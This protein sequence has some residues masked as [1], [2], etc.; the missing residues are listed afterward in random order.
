MR[1]FKLMLAV[2]VVL[3][4][5]FI[6]QA[7]DDEQSWQAWLHDGAG[8]LVLVNSNG[9]R[10]ERLTLPL[11][12]NVGDDVAVYVSS[13]NRFIAYTFQDYTLID[14]YML[15]IYRLE[16][17]SLMYEASSAVG[18]SHVV[19]N[20]DDSQLAYGVG[21]DDA[22]LVTVNLRAGTI[23]NRISA[24]DDRFPDEFSS[25][26]VELF[27]PE[28]YAQER[29][30]FSRLGDGDMTYEWDIDLNV[31]IALAHYPRL[32]KVDRFAPSDEQITIQNDTL[33]TY[34]PLTRTRAPFF[35]LQTLIH[36]AKFVG[37]GHLILICAEVDNMQE[38]WQLLRRDGTLMRSLP[39]VQR[40]DVYNV[41]EG[42]V[43]RYWN[44]ARQ[45]TELVHYD[46]S[47]AMSD[48]TVWF[49][50]GDW[51]IVWVDD[52]A[53]SYGPYIPWAQIGEPF[54]DP[55]MPTLDVA[56]QP[57]GFP[58][59]APIIYVGLT[60]V[61]NTVDGEVLYLRDEPSTGGGIV[62]NLLDGM[63]LEIIGESVEQDGFVWWQVVN[64][65]GL[66]GWAAQAVDTVTT[67]LPQ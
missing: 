62:M 23:I 43:Y 51:Q 38:A 44:D 63:E 52:G 11:P 21:G 22:E 19:F 58:T 36:E 64:E 17:N 57:T 55:P 39:P 48:N 67:L 26:A 15:W 18:F 4:G 49:A 6:A 45:I 60:V 53:I 16:D 7:D 61:V 10:L 12:D 37:N 5:L 27:M 47:R 50:E 9:E 25:Q 29:L 40:A 66:Q 41:V 3:G 8:R 42:F 14:S 65:D 46:T 33:I 32:N 56:I 54:V 34:D 2:I 1:R 13:L 28:Y 20:V 31:M 35:S 30:V 24:S 59:P